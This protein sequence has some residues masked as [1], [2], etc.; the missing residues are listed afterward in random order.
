MD[1][2]AARV[3]SVALPKPSPD[4]GL[5]RRMRECDEFFRQP[6][7]AH[8][9]R[10]RRLTALW[11]LRTHGSYRQTPEE[12]LIGA[13]LAW[14]NHDRCVGRSHWRSLD[15]IDARS[16]GCAA[17]LAAACFEHLR[18][19]FDGRAV[20]SLITVGP[21]ADPGGHP[22]R[23]INAQLIR[24]AGYPAP[25][26]TVIGDPDNVALTD[27]ARRLGWRGAHTAFDVL[28]LL[29][30]APGEPLRWF[31]LPPDVVREVPL[32]HP[33]HPWFAGLGLKW[34][35]IP[36]V[37]NM[38][39]EIGGITYPVAPFNGWYVS[40][41]IG[42]RNLSGH[43]RYDMLPVIAERL[44]LDRTSERTLWR[45]RALVELNIAVLHSYRKAGVY[46]V[47]HHTVAK[48]FVGHIQRE[49]AAG[50]G[51]PADWSW[52]NPPMSAGLTPTFHRYYDPPDP[53]TRPNFVRRN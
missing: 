2:T 12:I 36:A 18:R 31:P 20:R 42:A 3:P 45:D 6:E 35:A 4:A 16:A 30:S 34:H 28:P 52:I 53:T 10:R 21:P 38:D 37:S 1:R 23:I 49:A 39:L 50:R 44:G 41:E 26:G 46:I 19:A 33:E 48:Q 40:T 43:D 14:R 29:I 7:L 13:Q 24:Y 9:P 22:Y 25:D 5:A 51:C 32:E 27:L 15:L 47:D 17:D 11:Q 8:L